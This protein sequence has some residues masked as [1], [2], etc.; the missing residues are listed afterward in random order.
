[1]SAVVSTKE[2]KIPTGTLKQLTVVDI[3]VEDRARE[4]DWGSDFLAFMDTIREKGV[5]QPITVSKDMRLLAGGRRLEA[6]KRLKIEKIPALVRDIEDEGDAFEIELI[7]NVFR[8]NFKWQEQARLVAKIDEYYKTK[9]VDWSQRKTSTLLNQSVANTSRTIQLAR[10]ME[11]IPEIAEQKTADDA[12][13]VLKKLEEKIITAHLAAR[14]Q[15]E[16]NSGGGEEGEDGE[17]IE[18][19][20]P[21]DATKAALI[22][23]LR[24]AASNYQIGDVF[25]G[26]AKLPDNGTVHLIECDPPYGINLTAVKASKDSADSTVHDYKEVPLA[27]YQAFLSKLTK[28]LYRVAG[29]D[30]WLVFWFGP[31]WH[32]EVRNSLVDAGWQVDDI[33]CIWVKNQGQ[34][35]QPEVYLARYYEP[36]FMCRKGRPFV[37]NRGR[38]NVFEYATASAQQKY[39]PTERPLPLIEDILNT[40]AIASQTVL[41]PFLGSG[42]TLRAC[43]KLGMKGYGWDLNDGYRDRFLLAVEDDARTLLAQPQE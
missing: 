1:M 38:A 39:H 2:S 4:D 31:T 32:T 43:Y 42:A 10:A 33:P 18:Y 24:L 28:E 40:L 14:Q 3:R 13:K 29:P 37:L 15:E 6:C 7:E 9:N 35:L 30:A 16:L 22:N 12:L 21:E 41:V 34:T 20:T 17:P 8:A 25:E 36:F 27:D 23:R 5:L 19:A 11:S 26:L